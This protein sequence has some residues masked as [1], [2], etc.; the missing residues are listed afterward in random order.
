MIHYFNI[1]AKFGWPIIL[2]MTLTSWRFMIEAKSKPYLLLDKDLPFCWRAI[3]TSASISFLIIL[4]LLATIDYLYVPGMPTTDP[5]R[6]FIAFVVET[7]NSTLK[8]MWSKAPFKS[9]FYFIYCAI[10]AIVGMGLTIAVE[11]ET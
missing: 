9:V 8:A 11:C 4:A 6:A 3:A 1:I 7:C 2:G 10:G 5:F